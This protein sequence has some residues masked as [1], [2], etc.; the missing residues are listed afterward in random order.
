MFIKSASSSSKIIKMK[1]PS[2]RIQNKIAFQF[3]S[4]IPYFRYKKMNLLDVGAADHVLKPFL[5][6]NIRY[7]SL[8]IKDY[9]N[10][11][12]DFLLDLDRKKIPVKR[13]FFDIILCLDT[14]EH[15]MYPIKVIK[16]LKR[17]A[18]KDAIFIFSLP[19]EYNFLQRIYY[20]LAIKRKTEMPWKVVE[21][22]QHIH[23][24]RVKDILSLLSSEFK[25][26]KVKFH[27]ESRKSSNSKF[28]AGIDRI[29]SIMAQVYPNLFSRD[30]VVMCRNRG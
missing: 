28:F 19:N 8:D 30:V 5:P 3:L 18:K 13:G 10:C 21:E 4:R 15:T 17:V 24:P 2:D 26:I 12:Q 22:H 9:P 25:V 6:K 29:L 7:F 23:K 11:K 1:I 27:W 14:L 20:L 16:E